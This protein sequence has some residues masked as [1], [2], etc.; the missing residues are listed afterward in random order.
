MDGS[1]GDAIG[2]RDLAEALSVLAIDVK[3]WAADGPAFQTRSPHAG[4]H[5]LDD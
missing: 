4:T 5:S 2:P 3:R 1:S